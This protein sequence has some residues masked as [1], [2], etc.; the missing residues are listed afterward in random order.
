ML[1]PPFLHPSHLQKNNYKSHNQTNKSMLAEFL[2]DLIETK[3]MFAARSCND[4][5]SF[6]YS[7]NKNVKLEKYKPI[8]AIAA[9]FCTEIFK[10]RAT[11]MSQS[12][13]KKKFQSPHSPRC[14]SGEQ[15]HPPGYAL[16]QSNQATP[17]VT[18]LNHFEYNTISKIHGWTI[19]TSL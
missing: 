2:Q 13:I 3:P 8:L 16:H 9:A 7:H 17:E 4:F 18:K 5:K 6:Q 19:G 14:N 12:Q 1:L 15:R 11:F 10:F